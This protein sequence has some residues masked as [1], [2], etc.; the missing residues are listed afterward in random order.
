MP[1][2]LL[3]QNDPA[4]RNWLQSDLR[5]QGYE[6]CRVVSGGAALDAV[7]AFH[8]D[9]ILLDL[10]LPGLNGIGFCRRIRSVSPVPVILITS[11]GDDFDMIVGL[12]AGADD[13]IVQPVRPDVVHAR[14]RALLRRAESGGEGRGHTP[15]ELHGGLTI[16]RSGP[17]V[18]KGGRHLQLARFEL[19]LIL[20]LSESPGRIFS[21]GQ[22]LEHVWEHKH[23][24]GGR[25]V[26]ACVRRLRCKVE[27]TPRHPRYIQT[28]RG[29]GY[30]FGPVCGPEW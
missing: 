16:D 13:Y 17:F 4:A 5:R 15:T 7:D 20:H 25:I 28:A 1:R 24:C 11:R 12:D 18:A 8:P 9:L 3:V 23:D 27:D 6:V 22:L 14:V 29:L 19:K 26:D 30:R 2:I 10:M 21:R